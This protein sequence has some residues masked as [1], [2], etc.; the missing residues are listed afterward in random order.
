M[1]HILVSSNL[2][3]LSRNA[4]AIL[5]DS[6]R[7]VLAS[8]DCMSVAVSGGSTPTHLF[9]LL[10]SDAYRGQVKWERI[11]FF[12][13]DERCVP[14]E[15]KESNF[16]NA[17]RMLFSRIPIPPENI[18]RIRGELA[19]EEGAGLYEEDVRRHFGCAGLPVFDLIF[20]GMGEDGHTASLFPGYDEIWNQDRIAVPFFVER[21]KSWRITLTLPAINNASRVAFL[22]S[23]ASKAGIV[24]R[25][26][27]G[28]KTLPAG[29]ISPAGG[30]TTWLLDREA[31]ATI[32]I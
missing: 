21:L 31:A 2:E 27:G 12:W 29:L 22:V 19:P 16:G 7:E 25:V 28:D 32:T 13:V 15:D 18:H 26:L 6:M 30:E 4:A 8:R 9:A 14:V 10:A 3:E 24:G 23:G 11:H 20:L 1:Q 5:L 17:H